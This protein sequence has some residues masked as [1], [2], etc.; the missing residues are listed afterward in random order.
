MKFYAVRKGRKTGIFRE[1]EDCE[2]SVKGFS[3]ARYKKF[4]TEEEAN[5]FLNAGPIVIAD[6]NSER[7]SGDEKEKVSKK[8]YQLPLKN[9]QEIAQNNQNYGS[10]YWTQNSV[11]NRPKKKFIEEKPP[12]KPKIETCYSLYFD[13]GSRGNPGLSGSGFVIKSP[14]GDIIDQGCVFNGIKTNNEAEYIGLNL[15]L[16]RALQLGIDCINIYGDSELVINQIDGKYRCKNHTL[17]VQFDK[18][19][20]YLRN[21][22]S[23][24]PYS[25][26]HHLNTE[27]D[28]L[29]NLA[30]DTQSDNN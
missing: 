21:F 8:T 14:S 5:R 6:S 27:A 15:G 22:K 16:E 19:I 20:N 17:Q 10:T 2:A 13:G 7:S 4:A 28:Q 23:F 9:F 3:G 11:K 26:P 18:A 25:I 24:N 1:W 29:A 30:M 12:A